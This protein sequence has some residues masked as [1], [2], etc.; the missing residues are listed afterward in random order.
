M[1]YQNNNTSNQ[2]TTYE[3]VTIVFTSEI[4]AFQWIDYVTQLDLYNRGN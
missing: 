1:D 4:L 3:L 2:F